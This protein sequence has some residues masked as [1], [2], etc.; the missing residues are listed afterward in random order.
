MGERVD[1]VVKSVRQELASL[2]LAR[3]QSLDIEDA[4]KDLLLANMPAIKPGVADAVMAKLLD[5]ATGLTPDAELD[6]A[7]IA[8]VLGLRSRYAT[9]SK[10]LAD[11]TP[12]LDP[13][14]L[15]RVRR[16]G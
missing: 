9:P 4:A 5:P 2:D 7:G 3:L 11:P 15:Q 12:Y 14:F 1:A 16:V 10:E 13:S 6:A 8:S